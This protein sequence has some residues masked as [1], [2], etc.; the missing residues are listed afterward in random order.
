LRIANDRPTPV[1]EYGRSKRAGELAAERLA[2][3]VPTTV[4]RPAIVFGAT[5]RTTLPLFRPVARFGVQVTPGLARFRYSLIHVADLVRLIILA[6]QRGKRLTP[7]L[8]NDA[9]STGGYYFAACERHP[10][11]AELAHMIGALVGRSRVVTIPIAT[12]LIWLLADSAEV[13]AR[14][15]HRPFILNH[16]KASEMTAGSWACSPDVA[17]EELE[18]RVGAPLEQRLGETIAW[19]REQH[20]L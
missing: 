11:Y 15:C 16:D 8:G 1:S 12:P 10:T 13:V 4:V 19:Y 7:W 20:W 6:A 3:E 17:A 14:V 2:A 5:D 9:P 18:F